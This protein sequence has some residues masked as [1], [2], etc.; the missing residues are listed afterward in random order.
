MNPGPPFQGRV[1]AAIKAA[2]ER[3]ELPALEPGAVSYM[4]ANPSYLT[5]NDGHN[6]PHLM[7]Y[8][9]TRNR[10]AWSA[11]LPDSLVIG[12]DF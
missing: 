9:P 3:K 12:G 1:I 8:A 4:V 5:D 6:G 7:F 11:N 2:F 10:A